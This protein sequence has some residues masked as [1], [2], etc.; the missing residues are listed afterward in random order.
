M[1]RD[2]G[3]PL[4]VAALASSKRSR[5][6]FVLGLVLALFGHNIGLEYVIW[7]LQEDWRMLQKDE[8]IRV[9]M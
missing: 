4:T 1:A 8:T 9:V 3:L 7:L 5:A 6:A 2:R